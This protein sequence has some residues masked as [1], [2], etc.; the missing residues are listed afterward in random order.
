M[1]GLPVAAFVLLASYVAAEALVT[2]DW[3]Y[4]QRTLPRPW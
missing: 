4:R 1:A 3:R 2:V